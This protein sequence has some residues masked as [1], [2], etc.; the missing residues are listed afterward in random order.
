MRGGKFFGRTV[1]VL[2]SLCAAVL[3]LAKVR[4]VFF[5]PEVEVPI[6]LYDKIRNTADGKYTV[7]PDLFYKQMS[8]LASFGYRT[9]SPARVI[10]YK[11]WGF[12]LPRNPMMITF[13]RGGRET[14]MLAHPILK[15]LEM[16]AVVNLATTYISDSPDSVRTVN[17]EE[18]LSW[19][20]VRNFMEEGTFIFG[21][22]TRNMVDLTV[23]VKPFNEIRASR[24]DIKKRT[25]LRSCIFSYPFGKFDESIKKDAAEAKIKFA[26]GYGDRVASVGAGTDLLDMPRIRVP[27]GRVA[28]SVRVVVVRGADECVEIHVSQPLGPRFPLAVM[29]YQTGDPDP[30]ADVSVEELS[31]EPEC[32]AVL[33][34][35]LRFPITVDIL[36][37]TRLLLYTSSIFPKYSVEYADYASAPSGGDGGAPEESGTEEADVDLGLDLDSL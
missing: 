19:D 13:D 21:G 7:T 35:G 24:S 23:D 1:I 30:V 25:G 32:I 28:F 20:E 22:H 31:Q 26:M 6:F 5:L 11:N 9:V 15:S 8:D 3:V 10:A 4:A 34:S 33:P 18:M 17:G 14:L 2:F 37:G 12:P 29:A 16:T 27:G 36:D